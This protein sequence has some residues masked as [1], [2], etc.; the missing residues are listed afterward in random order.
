MAAFYTAATACYQFN[1]HICLR[2][3]C[4][5]EG[6]VSSHVTGKINFTSQISANLA[7]FSICIR[8]ETFIPFSEDISYVSSTID[9]TASGSG[10]FCRSPILLNKVIATAPP[11]VRARAVTE[12]RDGFL[13]PPQAW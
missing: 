2:C 9:T 8:P 7:C 10:P 1:G 12:L 4:R 3:L 11:R 5:V 13:R 6:G